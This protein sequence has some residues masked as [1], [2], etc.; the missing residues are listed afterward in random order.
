MGSWGVRKRKG[1]KMKLLDLKTLRWLVP[2][3]IVVLC[4]PLFIKGYS[5]YIMDLIG[6]YALIGLGLNLLTGVCGQ[7]SIGHS[8]FFAIGAFASAVFTAKF[9]I[10]FW[11]ALPMAGMTSGI[12]ALLVGIP[13]LRLKMI[14]L[15]IATIGLGVM[16]NNMLYNWEAVSGGAVGVNVPKPALGTLIFQSDERFFYIIVVTV[17]ILTLLYAHITRTRMG[18]AFLAIRESDIAASTMGIHVAKYKVL[19]FIISAFYTGVAGSL[20]AHLTAYLSIEGFEFFL[21]ITFLAMVIIGGIGTILGS[22][23][24]AVFIVL[25]P[26]LFRDIPGAKD[27]QVLVFGLAMGL[28]V[29]FRPRGLASIFVDIAQWL[30]RSLGISKIE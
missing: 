30:K 9:H 23:L 29:I 22:F 11:F 17:F 28:V 24:G 19:A 27:I 10:P 3:I 6:I 16:T 20:V 18:R 26:E 5:I 4:L 12:I 15:A 8:A 13:V 1:Y 2:L 14:F 25:L 21:S 7:I